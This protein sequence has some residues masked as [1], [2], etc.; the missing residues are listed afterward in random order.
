MLTVFFFFG[1]LFSFS[2]RPVYFSLNTDR[3]R[4]TFDRHWYVTARARSRGQELFNQVLDCKSALSLN[5]L[6][7]IHISINSAPASTVRIGIAFNL[8]ELKLGD[9]TIEFMDTDLF[10]LEIHGLVY[11]CKLS[12]VLIH[13]YG[14]KVNYTNRCCGFFL[15]LNRYSKSGV[16]RELG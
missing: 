6:S 3:W 16:L 8:L 7:S 10:S 9:E 4:T 11:C 15:E 5:L 13:C 12:S 2:L 14:I 1:K